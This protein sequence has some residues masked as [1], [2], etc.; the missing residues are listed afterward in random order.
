MEQFTLAVGLF[1]VREMLHAIR[2]PRKSL[3][4]SSPKVWETSAPQ[5]R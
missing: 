5:D 3:G 1:A 2:C 4:S